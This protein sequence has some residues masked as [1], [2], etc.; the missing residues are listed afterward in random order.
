MKILGLNRVELLVED[1]DIDAIVRKFNDV[2]GFKLCAPH[3]VQGQNLRS[4]V[5]F[6]AGLEFVSPMN[7]KSPVHA[8]LREKG[9]GA[10]LTTVWEVDDFDAARAWA[11]EKGLKVLLEFEGE[12]M[13]QLCL[14]PKEFFGYSVILMTRTG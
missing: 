6:D 3:E 11:R 7:E 8:V 5:D 10:L 4:S 12:G 13:R 1:R 2:F 9:R 14:D